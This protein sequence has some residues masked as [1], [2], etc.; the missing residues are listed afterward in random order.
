METE[1]LHKHS[2]RWAVML[3]ERSVV[4][5]TSTLRPQKE[6]KAGIGSEGLEEGE[7]VGLV[8]VKEVH[9]V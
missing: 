1:N 6:D 3:G 4:P 2:P 8:V 5:P 7:D 9:A